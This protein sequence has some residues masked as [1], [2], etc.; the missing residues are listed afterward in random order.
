[1]R[2]NLQK[3]SESLK[4]KECTLELTPGMFRA[5]EA[6]AF[7]SDSSSVDWDS[8]TIEDVQFAMNEII[9]YVAIEHVDDYLGTGETNRGNIIHE[10]LQSTILI[11][12]IH[13]LKPIDDH[14][15]GDFI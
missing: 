6:G 5:V 2:I 3:F 4:G 15:S 11:R 1:M 7:S 13:N 8:F 9:Q 14:E 12:S 10:Y